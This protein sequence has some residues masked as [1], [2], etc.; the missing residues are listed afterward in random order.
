MKLFSVFLLFASC[1]CSWAAADFVNGNFE[2]PELGPGGFNNSSAWSQSGGADAGVWNIF[3]GYGLF[4]A[5]APEGT[6][7]GFSNN[8]AMAQQSTRILTQDEVV[9]YAFAGR[10][11][12]F[13]AGSFRM[14]LWAGGTVSNGAVNGGTLL[15]S[16]DFDHTLLSPSTFVEIGAAYTPL[17]NDPLIGQLLSARFVRTAGSQMNM[18][19]VRF[20]TVP[21]PTSTAV[22]ALAGLV[23]GCTKRIRRRA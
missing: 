23:V 15:S 6:Q 9:L 17:V 13:F 18:D 4:D 11:A 20:F 3:P 14:E 1:H 2:S 7:I 5:E 19:H 21:E 8:A 10:R 16:V 12:D 22:L